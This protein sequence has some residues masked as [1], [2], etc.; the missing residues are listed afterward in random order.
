MRLACFVGYD[1]GHPERAAAQAAE[2]ADA[3]LQA[4]AVE[5]VKVHVQM[6]NNA[7]VLVLVWQDKKITYTTSLVCEDTYVKSTP[8][9]TQE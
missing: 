9:V 6:S 5:V 7:A 4:H 8:T 3:W 2:Q 1:N